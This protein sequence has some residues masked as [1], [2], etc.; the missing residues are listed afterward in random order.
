[1]TI[2]NQLV[3]EL[4]DQ[5][6]RLTNAR[7]AL[8]GI[9]GNEVPRKQRVMSADARERI[10]EAQRKRWARVRRMKKSK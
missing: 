5:I 2:Y 6:E 8:V 4:D 9:N 7:N 1:M 10:A 3:R